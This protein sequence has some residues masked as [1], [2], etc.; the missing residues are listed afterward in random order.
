[1]PKIRLAAL[2]AV[3]TAMPLAAQAYVRTDERC[4]HRLIHYRIDCPRSTLRRPQGRRRCS[5][6]SPSLE[7]PGTACCAKATKL[8]D[9]RG[10]TVVLAFFPGARTPG[11]TIQME[12]YRDAYGT[13]FHNGMPMWL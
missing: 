12:K 1:M 5:Q 10:Q 6:I 4:I 13:I 7:R 8:S 11:C 9:F 2:A 3:C